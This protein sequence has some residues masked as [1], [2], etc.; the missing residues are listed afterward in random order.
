MKLNNRFIFGILSLVLAAVIAFVALPTIARQTNGKAEIVRITQPVLKGEKITSDNAEVVEVGGYN[1]P[2]N[3]AHSLSD[4]EG[5]YV[6]ADLAE[7]DYILT[8]KVSSVPVSS[9]VALNDIPS[10]KVAI[11][12]TVKTLASGLSDKL[13]PND[14][15]RIYHF[16]ET[17]EEVPEL[18][19]V[20]VLSVTD[21]DGVNVDNTKE[22]T[23]DEERQQS[24]TI[25]VL[26]TPEQARIITE[27]ENDGVAHVALI[28]RNNDQLAEELLAA[29]D[30][31]LQEI[32][33]PETLTEDTKL[34]L[35]AST[36]ANY[37]YLWSNYVKDEPFANIPLPNIRKS[38]ILTFYTKL[39]K[40][41]FAINSLE[42]I[43]NLVHPALE[44]AVDDD[45]IRKN[46]SKGVYRSLKAEG[47]GKPAKKRIALTMT[48]QKNFLRFIS[49]SPMYS[50][51]LPVMVVLL[52]TGLRVG[53]CTGLTKND[54]DLENNTISVN[55]NL[56]YRVIDGEAGFHITTPKTASG[57]RTIPILY[58]Q[59]AEQL[60]ALIE[61]MDALY[62]E[63]LVMNGY[64]G[65]LFRNRSG[66][67]LSA[68]NINRAI[69][70]IS[71]A[72][73]A[74]EMD[75]AELEDREP[76]LLPHF[77]V[78]NLRHTFCTRLCEKTN[79]IKFI[80][81]VMGHADFST[82]MDIYTHITQESMKEKAEVIK[83]DLVLM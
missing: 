19:F 83:D 40:K 21:S 55:H 20:K 41:G 67:F 63:D 51:W 1:L 82:T 3:V 81:Q 76:N 37:E 34:Q 78:H 27:M 79:D 73:N 23:E 22:P 17:A 15:I 10:G 80:Q 7:G 72:Y 61:V 39:L 2:S 29:Q 14:I 4:V 8:S 44:L 53:E 59:V 70:R 9:D 50:H 57:T 52:G 42:N 13:Q 58:P 56:I 6:T 12:M 74:E 18:R 77:S 66:Y 49:K 75:Q 71:I 36:R 69:E 31:T 30:K 62:P 65:F 43:N 26:A 54:V 16:L 64:H 38:D 60:R 45:Y 32:Y 5:L 47:A 46:P 48:Q 25:T 68:H 11:S 33:F 28:S 24:A 35:K